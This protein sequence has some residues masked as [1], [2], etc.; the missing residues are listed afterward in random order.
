MPE[1]S[2][3][4][5]RYLFKLSNRHGIDNDCGSQVKRSGETEAGSAEEQPAKGEPDGSD[6]LEKIVRGVFGL[7]TLF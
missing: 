1:T 7:P 5:C 3:R 2:R 4:K 6:G